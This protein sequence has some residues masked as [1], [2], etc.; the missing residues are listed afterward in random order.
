MLI[1]DDTSTV[2]FDFASAELTEAAKLLLQRLFAATLDLRNYRLRIVDHTDSIG[3]L[4]DNQRLSELRTQAVAEYL[5]QIGRLGFAQVSTEGAG[6]LRP[7]APNTN[8]QGRAR[9]RR[10]ELI[11]IPLVPCQ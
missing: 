3:S 11:F 4:D 2:F 1:E 8:S 7:V 9:N 10:V 6:E 5:V